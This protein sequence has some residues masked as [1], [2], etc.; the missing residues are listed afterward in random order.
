MKINLRKNNDSEGELLYTNNNL[1]WFFRIGATTKYNYGFTSKANSLEFIRNQTEL[2][3]Q[4]GGTFK[5]RGE[6]ELID[7]VNKMGEKLKV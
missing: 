5:L 4:V 1:I 2:D 6:K 7:V 3:W